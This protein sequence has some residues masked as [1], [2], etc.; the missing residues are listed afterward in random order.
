MQRRIPLMRFGYG[1]PLEFLRIL[2]SPLER[3]V[4]FDPVLMQICVEQI[5]EDQFHGFVL[6]SDWSSKTDQKAMADA[7]KEGITGVEKYWSYQPRPASSCR[8]SD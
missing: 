1:S 8:K 7:G 2:S 6:R 3:A 4:S 5:Y